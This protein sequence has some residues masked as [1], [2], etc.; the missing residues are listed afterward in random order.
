MSRTP[1]LSR[2]AAGCAIL[3]GLMKTGFCE[4]AATVQPGVQDIFGRD[5]S[6]NGII[7][8]DWEGYMANPA[9]EFFI[10]PPS[11][12][13]FPVDVT[14][15]AAEPRLYF[16]LPSEAGPNG[17]G[18]Q[19]HITN[20]A[21]VGLSVAIFPARQKKKLDTS[22]DIQMSDARGRKWQVSAPVHVVF[23]EAHDDSP[24]FPINVDFSQ[25]KTGFYGDKTHQD[26]FKQAV[27]DWEFYLADMHVASVPA[28]SERT[29]IFERDGFRRNHEVTNANAYTGFLLYTYGILGPEMRSGGEP[30]RNGKFQVS[31]TQ[32]LPM[33]RSGGVEVEIDGNYNRLGWLPPLADDEWWMATN[34]GKERND[35]IVHHEI[36]HALFFNPNNAKFPRGG[37]IR[38]KVIEAYL[39]ADVQA[40]ASDHF[41]GSIDPASLH[42]AFGNEYH[43]R[44]PPGRWLITK[45]DLLCVE[46]T[47]YKLRK[48]DALA[49]LAIQTSRLPDAVLGKPYQASLAAEGGIPFYDWGISAGTLPAGLSLDRFS[50]QIS[51]TP[52]TSGTIAFTILLRDY[53]KN[54]KGVSQQFTITM[55]G[56]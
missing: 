32:K 27:Q 4:A 28:H 21:P 10:I 35:S 30:S 12:A 48:V 50:G 45:L 18:K 13:V 47:S 25:D 54:T 49:P 41:G 39:G 53:T 43:G 40:D 19:L 31:G 46:A 22:L 38:D 56:R 3:L 16:D 34:L 26:L 37:V 7:L 1:S 33:K 23:T 6:A 44:T 51:G 14:V 20:A 52:T 36:G 17:P 42:G 9:I 29:V 15:K 8:V 55:S 11:D 5:I 24:T 2:Y